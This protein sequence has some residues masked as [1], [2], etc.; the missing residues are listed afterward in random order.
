M[1]W[2]EWRRSRINRAAH[3]LPSGW[4]GRPHSPSCRACPA[5]LSST[6]WSSTVWTW[7]SSWAHRGHWSGS[8]PFQEQPGERGRSSAGWSSSGLDSRYQPGRPSRGWGQ[9]PNNGR[10]PSCRVSADAASAPFWTTGTSIHV[11][12]VD[13]DVTLRA[14]DQSSVLK[15]FAARGM[16]WIQLLTWSRPGNVLTL[17]SAPRFRSLSTDTSASSKGTSSSSGLW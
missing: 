4:V 11:I 7:V 8:Q 1:R 17:T 14:M 2:W 6:R 16:A 12:A 13:Q 10:T 9:W 15:Y 3:D 5:Q